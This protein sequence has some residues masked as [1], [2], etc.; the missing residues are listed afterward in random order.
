[1]PDQDLTGHGTN[2]IH[3]LA[4][5]ENLSLGLE[6]IFGFGHIRIDLQIRINYI[7]L[8]LVL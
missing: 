6:C 8:L 1:V 4:A 7:V 2:V 3:F 5:R